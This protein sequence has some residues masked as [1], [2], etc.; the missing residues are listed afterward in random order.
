MSLDQIPVEGSSSKDETVDLLMRKYAILKS[1]ILVQIGG[2]KNHVRNGQV[3]ATVVVAVLV[4]L[5]GHN[6]YQLSPNTKYVWLSV[7]F[8]IVTITYY[9]LY[10]VL[11]S[12]FAVECISE[13]IISLENRIN[14]IMGGRGLIWESVIVKKI[15][16]SA[17]PFPGVIHPFVCELAYA[18]ILVIIISVLIPLYVYY[19]ALTLEHNGIKDYVII[20]LSA[21][22]SILSFVGF[23]FMA[24]KL[25]TRV[26]LALKD[27]IQKEWRTG[28]I[29]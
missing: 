19:S 9:L 20:G 2:I 27:L 1:D 26:R 24:I 16:S 7:C 15:V 10:D 18:G 3:L 29:S 23:I 5:L 28:R 14:E 21:V 13:R 11:E 4:F 25:H 8:I 22:Y 17:R 6:E 12:S